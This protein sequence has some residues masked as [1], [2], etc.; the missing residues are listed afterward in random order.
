M[1]KVLSAG[2]KTCILRRLLYN[3]SICIVGKDAT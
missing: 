3:D 1:W 2:K